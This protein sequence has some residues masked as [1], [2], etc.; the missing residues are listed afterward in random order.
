MTPKF[1]H[2]KKGYTLI[3][4]VIVIGLVIMISS[5]LF[6]N[7]S[8][9]RGTTALNSTTKQIAVLLREAQSRAI[10]GASSTSWG[11]HFNSMASTS[12]YALFFGPVYA[13]A[14][15]VGHYAMPT[16]VRFMTSTIPAGSSS[17]VLFAPLSGT[18][19]ATATIGLELVFGPQ[20]SSTIF[21]NSFGAISH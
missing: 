3:E 18:P 16:Q 5:V 7:L 12:F 13:S 14:T 10:N 21:V 9:D 4:L 1:F 11:V 19:N 17:T 20:V 6:L 2:K 15:E 8:G